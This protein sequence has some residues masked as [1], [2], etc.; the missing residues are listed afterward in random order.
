[1]GDEGSAHAHPTDVLV[2]GRWEEVMVW[3][4]GEDDMSSSMYVD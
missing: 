3:D 2:K 1:M 4:N